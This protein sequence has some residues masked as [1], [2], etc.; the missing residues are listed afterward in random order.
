MGQD[1]KDGKVCLTH[2]VNPEIKEKLKE[3]AKSQ[4]RS[5]NGMLEYILEEHFKITEVK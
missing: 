1:R 4:H 3:A 5:M 2:Y